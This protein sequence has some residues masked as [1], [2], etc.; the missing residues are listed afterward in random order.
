MDKKEIYKKADEMN[1]EISSLIGRMN[2]MYFRM[3]V[4]WSEE[5]RFKLGDASAKLSQ[6]KK[7]LSEF[8][9]KVYNE[10]EEKK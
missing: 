6:A 7:L 8:R 4:D 1:D 9:T 3:A 10:S 5:T 2:R